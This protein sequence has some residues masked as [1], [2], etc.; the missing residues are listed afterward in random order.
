MDMDLHGSGLLHRRRLL[1]AGWTDD[2]VRA[3]V[4][5]GALVPLR[6]GSYLSAGERPPDAESWHVLAVRAALPDLAPQVVISHVSAA[7]LHGLPVWGIALNRITATRSR[8]SGAR[9]TAGMHLYAAPLDPD[10]IA[11]MGTIAVTSA[12][13]TVADIA[14]SLP[15]EQAVSLA[16]AAL[17]RGL[18]T[19]QALQEALRRAAGRPGCPQARRAIAF[20]DGRSESVGE[21]RSRVA[22]LRAGL[23]APELQW[24]FV[25]GGRELGR[26]DFWWPRLRTVGE[27]D[28]RIKYG[29]LLEPGQAP[30]DVVFAEKRR[31]DRIREEGVRFVRWTWSEITPFDE[32]AHRLRR[33]FGEA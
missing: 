22:M 15:F 20:A 21:S 7:V 25:G 24:P 13:R 19:P 26:V 11:T 32:V 30:G 29:R 4:R 16:D 23:P 33:A 2:E 9:R 1:A 18:T 17:H 27:F 28:G 14:R 5:D 8:R 12:A 10:E 3:R 31:E 6:R